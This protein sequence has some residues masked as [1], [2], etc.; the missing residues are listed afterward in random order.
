MRICSACICLISFSLLTFS[1]TGGAVGISESAGGRDTV[2]ITPSAPAPAAADTQ[3]VIIPGKSGGAT[4][5][6][7]FIVVGDE[8]RV[9]LSPELQGVFKGAK[10][11]TTVGLIMHAAGLAMTLGGG[12]STSQSS[13]A[14]LS[15][16]ISL[17]GTSALIVGPILSCIG[18]TKVENSLSQAGG[19]AENPKVWAEYGW[20]WAF[21]GGTMV[22]GT[23]G[24][25]LLGNGIGWDGTPINTGGYVAPF[26]LV[27]AIACEVFSE[28]QWM[29]CV[30]HSRTYVS[31]MERKCKGSQTSISVSPVFTLDGRKGARLNV[32]F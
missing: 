26:L 11:L 13:D 31:R 16:S 27:G 6:A 10:V 17:V 2:V 8:S 19:Q 9:P 24:L 7:D 18:A 1:E 23:T 3:K 4:E 22:L 14:V 21:M 30:I 12:A 29:K 5:K 32:G 20:G 28:I 15:T 25:V